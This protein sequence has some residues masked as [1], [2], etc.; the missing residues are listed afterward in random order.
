MIHET[1]SES[2]R[3]RTNS[4][5]Q[6]GGVGDALLSRQAVVI[7]WDTVMGVLDCSELSQPKVPKVAPAFDN[8]NR[9]SPGDALP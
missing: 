3:W 8:D 4:F 7:H 6:V 2:C 1:E 9:Q 5:R